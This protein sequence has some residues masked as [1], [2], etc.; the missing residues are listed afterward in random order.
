MNIYH[1]SEKNG[2]FLGSSEAKRDPIGN[3][4]MIPAN[5]TEQAPPAPGA[6][7]AARWNGEA[8]EIVPDY[9]GSTWYDVEAN[10]HKITQ[11]N[12]EPDLTWTTLK[13]ILPAP[14]P[15]I[16]SK[17]QA[18]KALYLAGRLADV[19]AAINAMPEPDKTLSRIDWEKATQ[20]ERDWP[21]TQQLAT[22]LGLTQADL[23]DLFTTAAGL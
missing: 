1:Y 3:N 23:D 8:W 7:Q 13:P 2:E 9:R 4:P 17:R 15:T 10:E 18:D 6:K 21:L 5:A 22:G 20:I 14:V 12:Q 16:V 11:I 19:E